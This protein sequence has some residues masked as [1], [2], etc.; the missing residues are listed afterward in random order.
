MKFLDLLKSDNIGKTVSDE[1]IK[2][3]KEAVGGSFVGNMILDC[4]TDSK[5]REITMSTY[6]KSNKGC[7]TCEYW[8][9]T[10]KPSSSYADVSSNSK[11]KCYLNGGPQ[12]NTDMSPEGSCSKWKQWAVLS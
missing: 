7:A 6:S 9:G 5:E 8:G 10:R 3:A 11:A 12:Y 2:D 1:I 4:I